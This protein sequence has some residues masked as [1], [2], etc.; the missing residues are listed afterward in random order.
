M[1]TSAQEKESTEVI[2]QVPAI[3]QLLRKSFVELYNDECNPDEIR[4]EL[5]KC[6]DFSPT[7]LFV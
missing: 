6:V 5:K 1:E 4:G 7:D 2:L 3:K